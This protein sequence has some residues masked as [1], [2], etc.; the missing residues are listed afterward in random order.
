ML[1]TKVS[2]VTYALRSFNKTLPRQIRTPPKVNTPSSK[3]S[4]SVLDVLPPE[5][6][7]ILKCYH[8][9]CYDVPATE[10]PYISL[11]GSINCCWPR[12]VACSRRG[13]LLGGAEPA[14]MRCDDD[15]SPSSPTFLVT[16][17]GDK[18]KSSSRVT[19]VQKAVVRN[20]EPS[21]LALGARPRIGDNNDNRLCMQL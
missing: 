11:F 18:T 21:Q 12:A 1:P 17:L 4:V 2:T 9:S 16:N 6:V 8:I 20:R 13:S 3:W 10:K 15:V 7:R 19:T 14:K 5:R